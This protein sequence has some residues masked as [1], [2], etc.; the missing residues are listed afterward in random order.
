MIYRQIDT[1][2]CAVRLLLYVAVKAAK[3]IGEITL[4]NDLNFFM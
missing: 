1:A 2:L 3:T 4:D